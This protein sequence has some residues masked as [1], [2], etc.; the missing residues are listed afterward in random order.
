MNWLKELL[1]FNNITG[2]RMSKECGISAPQLTTIIK[3]DTDKDNVKYGQVVAIHDFIE[4][5]GGEWDFFYDKE[6]FK[7]SD[8]DVMYTD[9]IEDIPMKDK[10][11]LPIDV[12]GLIV[13]VYRVKGEFGNE[14]CYS[15][16]SYM[17]KPHLKGVNLIGDNSVA[18]AL[19]TNNKIIS[20]SIEE[21][22]ASAGYTKVN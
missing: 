11:Y 12:Y 1:E 16:N 22:F 8:H 17:S 13:K 14:I 18:D 10:G 6:R 15:Y 21:Y 9:K 20:K 4:K 5:I 7:L 19:Y 2:Y 3:R